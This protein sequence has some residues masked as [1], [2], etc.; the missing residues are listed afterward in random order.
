MAAMG[1]VQVPSSFTVVV[2]SP[3]P[4]VTVMVEPG[5]PVPVPLM[6]VGVCPVTVGAAGM[7]VMVADVA[8]GVRVSSPG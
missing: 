4:S 6:L 5:V 3:L 8:D 2:V 1:A 7:F